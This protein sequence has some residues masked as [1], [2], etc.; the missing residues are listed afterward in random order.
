MSTWMTA[1]KLIGTKQPTK[2]SKTKVNSHLEW[3]RLE[4]T[5]ILKVYYMDFTVML[6]SKPAKEGQA[7]LAMKLLTPILMRNGSNFYLI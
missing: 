4:N 3:V 5:S 1:G 2:L 6:D 7:A